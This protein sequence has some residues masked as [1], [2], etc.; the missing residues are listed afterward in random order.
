MNDEVMTA[1]KPIVKSIHKYVQ[2]E[3]LNFQIHTDENIFSTLETEWKKLA[4]LSNQM[5]CMSSGWASSWW[6]HF[7]CHKNRSLFIVTV[8][9]NQKLVAIF[10]F[11]KGI[12]TVGGITIHQRLQL[13]GS[14]GS[15]NE[16]LGFLD[17]YGIS[18]F[19]DI[20][21]DPEYKASI[22]DLFVRFLLSPELSDH[23]ITFQQA[24]D[25]SYIMQTIYPLLK[26]SKRKVQ[27]EKTDVCYYVKVDQGGGLKEF[28]KKSKSN[29]RR[30]FRQT[31]RAQGSENEYTIEEAATMADFEQMINKLI[32]LH[33]DRWNKIGFPGAFHDVRF[34]AFFKEISLAAFRDNSL[35][36]KQAIDEGGVCSVRMLL[37]YNG[38]YY[39]YMSGYD[40]DSPSSRHRPGI[41][42]LLD[43]VENSLKQP[44]DR[45]E[46]LRG[47]E[48]YKN[49]FTNLFHE[50]WKVTIPKISDW[51]TGWGLPATL[52][53]LC[54]ILYKHLNRERILL[55]VQYRKAGVLYMLSGYLKFRKDTVLSKINQLKEG[56]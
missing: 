44:V 3:E 27:A 14:G 12:T 8:Y 18:D 41:G 13:I 26:K 30:R 37:M 40:D 25:D 43:L 1:T 53:Q 4:C 7:G 9:D 33:Q 34:I 16:Q 54:A 20:I 39:D 49:D 50:N 42:L 29:A 24:R 23:E 15:P 36:L 5:I 31:L 2:K 6:K 22:A 51:K 47:D 10:P 38:R 21:V 48:G 46:L 35:W 56:A 17:D 28:I 55:Q 45:I 52:V 19:L 32:Q 11:Y